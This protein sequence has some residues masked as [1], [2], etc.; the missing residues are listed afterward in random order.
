MSL[1]AE[2]PEERAFENEGDRNDTQ[3]QERVHHPPTR[4]K[5]LDHLIKHVGDASTARAPSLR[6]P[7]NPDPSIQQGAK[8]RTS[9]EGLAEVIDRFDTF[10]G[11]Y[12]CSKSLPNHLHQAVEYS[13]LG[14]GKRLR[15]ALAWYSSIA[16]AGSGE[17]ALLAG[18]GVELIHAFSLIH[19]DLPA[20][21]NDD[22]RR[23]R[24]TLHK[25][26]GEAMAILAGDALMSLAYESVLDHHD[27][28]VAQRLSQELAQG[29]RAMIAGQVYDTLGG[30]PIGI[31]ERDAVEL[32]HRNKTGALLRASCRMGAICARADDTMLGYITE[33]AESIGLQF[34]IIDDLLDVEG[35]TETVGKA[36]G[37]DEAAGKRTYP[38]LLGVEG[39]RALAAELGECADRAISAL[40]TLSTGNI[41]PLRQLGEM[42]THRN[43]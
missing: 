11:E 29:T 18:T 42:L 39:S 6:S 33:Y 35:S 15:P 1:R 30:L 41:T 21:D 14:G 9:S 16:C 8:A 36:L 10:I 24:P 43:A 31:S 3:E 32:I 23:G 26:A 25:H 27:P 22:L 2:D 37:K 12:F 13:V 28:V 34:Q 7:V 4:K 5:E 19:D 40:E 17:D 38:A 20:L